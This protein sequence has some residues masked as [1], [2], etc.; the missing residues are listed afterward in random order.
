MTQDTRDT[1][2][3]LEAV[4]P[5]KTRP[6]DTLYRRI[7]S[8]LS[9]K[10]ACRYHV[11]KHRSDPL[12]P[13]PPAILPPKNLNLA[14]EFRH[15]PLDQN[16]PSMRLI[17]I[18][19]GLSPTGHIQCRIQGTLI[20][21]QPYHCLSYEWGTQEGDGY[22]VLNG[23]LMNVRANLLAFL[24]EAASWHHPE[25]LLWIDALCIDQDNALERNHQVRQMG[26]IYSNALQVM[27]WL[28]N[29]GRTGSILSGL[30]SEPFSRS[31]EY[32]AIEYLGQ[33][34]Y[35]K[36]AWITQEVSL[37]RTVLLVGKGAAID[38]RYLQH[39]ANTE[40]A[41]QCGM[42]Q[43]DPPNEN[44]LALLYE[45]RLQKCR[46]KRD[47]VYLLLSLCQE[48]HKVNV[49]YTTSEFDVMLSVLH[50]CK[51]H[52]CF[53]SAFIVSKALDLSVRIYSPIDGVIVHDA[54]YTVHDE[55]ISSMCPTC[56]MAVRP[57]P[58]V[59]DRSL[60]SVCFH[61]LCSAIP[62]HATWAMWN[63]GHGSQ[64]WFDFG[65]YRIGKYYQ[66]SARIFNFPY[67]PLTSLTASE[68]KTCALRLPI[69]F[70][71]GLEPE[72]SSAFDE[73]LKQEKGFMSLHHSSQELPPG[74]VVWIE[75]TL[76]QH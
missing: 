65:S 26:A 5:T 72:Y 43:R 52:L 58:F 59:S 45:Y 35:W 27:V 39:S 3:E 18:L 21:D 60:H 10:P 16:A 57:L 41:R 22:I 75:N 12:T 24:S 25:N 17:Q 47:I 46:N 55:R 38:T 19:P 48:G 54:R 40:L 64:I 63:S 8:L 6:S 28:G 11:R 1:S 23:R 34:S 4:M 36:R 76:V 2:P 33:N 71:V 66:T 53:C 73:H 42:R 74:P 13:P 67:Y 69:S 37:A 68:H 32:E 20:G 62:S 70:L 30:W 49:D 61:N 50:V 29:D 7:V 9:R 31:L 56:F 14:E 15:T 51:R 44:L